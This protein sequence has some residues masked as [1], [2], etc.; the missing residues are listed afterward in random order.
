MAQRLVT[1]FVNT[2]IPS[3]VVDISV[4]SQPVGLGASGN[5]VIIG[6]ADG[7]DNFRNVDLKNSFFTPD[8]SDKAQQMFIS[9]PI[10]DA[11]RALSAPSNDTDITGTANRIYV[12]KTNTSAK[13][14][15]VVDSD[16]GTFK[17]QNWGVNGNKYKFQITSTQAEVAPSQAGGTIPAFGAALNGASFTLRLNGGA[18]TV[19]TLSATAANHQDVH[20][21]VTELNT[22]LPSGVTASAGTAPSTIVISVNVDNAAY[23]KGW[24][25]ALEFIDSTPG[26]LAA[27]GLAVQLAVS[28][29]EPAVE[30]SVSRADISFSETLDAS[31]DVALMVG[32]AGTTGTLTINATTLTTTI[33]GGSGANLSIQ[34]SQY[35]TVQDLADFIN[36]QT[37]YSAV[38]SSAAQQLPPS[39]LDEVTAIG[40]AAT[41]ASDKP[42]R[43]KKALYD[44]EQAMATSRALLFTNTALAGLP[45]PMANPAFLAGGAKGG[46]LAADVIAA[47]NALAGLDV[48]IIVPLFSRDASADIVD[49]LTDSSSTYTIAAVH[50][51]VKNHCIQ[52]STP[53]LKKNRLGLLSF[54]GSYVDAKTRSQSL[55]SARCAMT[56]QRV[57]QENSAGNLVSFLPW[58]AACV[59]AGMQAGGFYKSITNKFA[60]VISVTDPSG[61]DNGSPGDVEDALAAG[62]MVLTAESAGVRWVSDQTTYGFDA[63]FVY[64]SFQAMYLADILAL[65]LADS[66]QRAFVGKSLAD[67]DASTALSFLA[68]KMDG[69]KK[70]KMIAASD[71]APLGYKN[72]KVNILAPE[73]DIAVEVKLATAIYFVPISLSISQVQQSA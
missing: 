5:I 68:Q 63:N 28:A 48:N 30:V 41:G 32:Y 23:R 43:V 71:D 53:K 26:D 21:L 15:A 22:L 40:I 38:A 58:Y 36:S 59:A 52:Y 73:M 56:M 72:P 61:Y 27:L 31:A 62:I 51:A 44:F 1:P 29:S 18:A 42:G 16:Y 13:A 64:N 10:V 66:F 8:Q 39:A 55:A 12:V 7:G 67:V 50:A 37:G 47:I 9:G 46:T 65:D 57:T 70:L 14:S 60:N 3:A 6:E 69:Y 20:S 25:K 34:L 24:G 45:N 19:V 49:G 17:D 11:V 4:K 33:V 2:T 54:F 35:R